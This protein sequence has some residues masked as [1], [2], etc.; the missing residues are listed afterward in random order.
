MHACNNASFWQV[1]LLC[2]AQL[3]GGLLLK[4]GQDVHHAAWPGLSL[5][6]QHHLPRFS[7]GSRQR[8]DNVSREHNWLDK[9]K[10]AV[11]G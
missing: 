6:V 8:V 3:V 4:Q 11:A 5:Q 1:A 2:A 10:M 7:R 9:Y